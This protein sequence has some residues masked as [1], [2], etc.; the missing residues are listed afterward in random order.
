MDNRPSLNLIII[1]VISRGWR[2]RPKEDDVS[3]TGD[4][5]K[6]RESSLLENME[7]GGLGLFIITLEINP[8][9]Q[10]SCAADAY[11]AATSISRSRTHSSLQL[12]QS[13]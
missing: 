6:C 9:L 4:Q 7:V 8:Q 5:Q 10:S 11:F 13:A 3:K 1:I 2:Q 12:Q